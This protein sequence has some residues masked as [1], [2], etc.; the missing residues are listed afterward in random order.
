MNRALAL[1][2]FLVTGCYESHA[3]GGVVVRRDG[4]IVL[5]PPSSELFVI[6]AL[7]IPE[8]AGGVAPGA[9]LDAMDSGIGSTDPEA[10]CEEYSPDFVSPF[11]G[12]R[13]VDDALGMLVPTIEGFLEPGA[14]DASLAEMI[15]D[16]DVVIGIVI[17][18]SSMSIE[19]LVPETE[20][21]LDATGR[22][23]AGQRFF[24]GDRLDP[25]STGSG[26]FV[27]FPFVSLPLPETISPFFANGVLRDVQLRFTR[28]AS[29][30]EGEI[31][32]RLATDDLI[33][34]WSEV[35][36]SLTETVRDLLQTV[37]DLGP[38]PA[39]PQMCTSLSIGITWEA[40]SGILVEP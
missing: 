20:V 7:S 38:S 13:G 12:T 21:L 27:T 24:S 26:P 19:T 36:P 33:A 5:P 25:G 32:A 16:R 37:A 17:R 14:V 3:P 8:P 29:G 2:F 31:G 35:D 6:T 11:D 39:S 34:G 23:A 30:A 40:V 28:S 15:R 9:N 22:I 10:T 4:G 1:C 18:G